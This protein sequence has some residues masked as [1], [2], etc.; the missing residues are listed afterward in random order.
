MAECWNGT[1]GA[2]RL[3]NVKW[4]IKKPEVRNRAL[5]VLY[6]HA[7]LLPEKELIKELVGQPKPE[8]G[9]QEGAHSI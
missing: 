4:E 6:H 3:D 2:H 5:A 8:W 1:G 7:A 9:R